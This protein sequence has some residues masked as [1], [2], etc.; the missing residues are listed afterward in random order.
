MRYTIAYQPGALSEYEQAVAWYRE[1]SKQAAE[2]FEAAMEERMAVLRTQP[3]RYRKTYKQFHET[4][5][6]KYP[7]S[8]IYLI[9]EK[10]KK[11][12]IS[13]IFHHKRNPKRK[14]RK[15]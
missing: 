7:F 8:I 3:A 10:E 11:V 2:N 1:R 6:K 9:S 14:Y 13:S 15:S 4:A 12:I 5:L